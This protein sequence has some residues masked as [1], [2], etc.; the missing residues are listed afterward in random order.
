MFMKPLKI[1]LWGIAGV[2]IVALVATLAAPRA[3]H[4]LVAALVQVT[5][6]TANPVPVTLSATTTQIAS[7]STTV[8]PDGRLVEA[9]PYDVSAYSTVRLVGAPA[10]GGNTVVHFQLAAVDT[11]GN[12]FPLDEL[13]ATGKPTVT[14]V[15]QTPGTQVTVRM[16][17]GCPPATVC[18]ST[19]ANFTLYGR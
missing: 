2:V 7:F 4:A 19:Q 8:T 15:V 10:A 13:V 17:G 3:A 1:I 6:T 11:S 14:D 12:E 16:F 5:N 9:G 18:T